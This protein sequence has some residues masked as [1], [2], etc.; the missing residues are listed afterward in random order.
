MGTVLEVNIPRLTREGFALKE[1]AFQVEAGYLTAL[2]GVNGAGKTT[3]LS[4]ISGLLPL[5]EG[6]EVKICGYSLR[7]KEKEAKECMGFVFDDSPFDEGMSAM[8]TGQMYGPYYKNW[9]EK[10]TWNI[11]NGLKFQ[12]IAAFA[13]CPKE[14][15]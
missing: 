13:S 6:A 1:I 4:A 11:W 14:C 8:F 15:R 10:N 5:P 9:N 12:R 7:E 2:L 3:L